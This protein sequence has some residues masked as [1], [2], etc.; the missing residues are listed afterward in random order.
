MGKTMYEKRQIVLKNLSD[1][2]VKLEKK[3]LKYAMESESS[4]QK[5]L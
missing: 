4:L 3:G 1:I 2:E 5:V